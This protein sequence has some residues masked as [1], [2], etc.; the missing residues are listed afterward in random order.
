LPEPPKQR[1]REQI[2][3]QRPRIVAGP[4]HRHRALIERLRA[5]LRLF[6]AGFQ[7]EHAQSCV[8]ELTRQGDPGNA[9]AGDDDVRFEA[10]VL[11]QLGCI[12]E[13]GWPACF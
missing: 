13:H 1:S 8:R 6:A 12:D 11:R 7:N 10:R 9:A 3:V 5:L 2:V 4:A